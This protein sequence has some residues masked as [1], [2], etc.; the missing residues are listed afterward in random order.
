MTA[1]MIVN[2][3]KSDKMPATEAWKLLASVG[4]GKKDL[5]VLNLFL[6]R[7]N[8]K[9]DTVLMTWHDIAVIY[10]VAPTFKNIDAITSRLL[11]LRCHIYERKHFGSRSV[12]ELI[13]IAKDNDWVEIK[14]CESAKPLLCALKRAKYQ[15]QKSI[16]ELLGIYI[17]SIEQ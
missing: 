15:A 2:K 12:F 1:M 5:D 14:S 17:A 10:E 13:S 16:S 3:V 9:N 4:Y 7:W 8:V 6:D 11:T